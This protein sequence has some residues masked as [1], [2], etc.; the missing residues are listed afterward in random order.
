MDLNT[1]IKN[2][3]QPNPG[4]FILNPLVPNEPLMISGWGSSGTTGMLR[5]LTKLDMQP[6]F[7]SN[8][9]NQEDP[10]LV[11]YWHK[12]D[13]TAIKEDRILKKNNRLCKVPGAA[14]W[15]A[16]K[17]ELSEAWNGQW[18]IMTRDPVARAFYWKDPD[19]QIEHLLKTL[20]ETTELINAAI[21]LAK[22]Y[23][24]ILVCYEKLLIKPTA[25]LT[26]IAEMLHLDL[27]K[28]PL[29]VSEIIPEDP[30][31]RGK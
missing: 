9:F 25:V 23:P 15:A 17:P 30:R 4:I 10:T 21:T 27:A 11:H 13:I 12:K 14:I 18:L 8:G 28:I 2:N 16:N 22:K 26:N 7:H 5:A 24:C 19:K 1:I 6:Y 29:A 20:K 3:A 31:Y